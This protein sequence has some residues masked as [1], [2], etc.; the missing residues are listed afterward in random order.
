M[1]QAC[2][3]QIDSVYSLTPEKVVQNAF[4]ANLRSFAPC[5]SAHMADNLT[6]FSDKALRLV[7]PITVVRQCATLRQIKGLEALLLC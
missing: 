6:R 2:Q 5:D 4:P 1:R 7:K 3:F